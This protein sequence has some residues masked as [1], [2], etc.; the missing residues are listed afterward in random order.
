MTKYQ[1]MYLFIKA[2]TIQ[3]I[4]IPTAR[5]ERYYTLPSAGLPSLNNTLNTEQKTHYLYSFCQDE[6]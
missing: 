5:A 1:Q 6:V 3:S 2:L 4:T